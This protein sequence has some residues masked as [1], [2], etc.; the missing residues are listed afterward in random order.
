MPLF[1]AVVESHDLVETDARLPLADINRETEALRDKI[2]ALRYNSCSVPLFDSG[3]ET[4]ERA[5]LSS[6]LKI[7]ENPR[8]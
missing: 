5:A 4:S 6:E 1:L 7:S 3:A 2:T 8:G